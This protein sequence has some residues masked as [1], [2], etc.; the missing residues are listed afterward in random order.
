MKPIRKRTKSKGD[1]LPT[2]V[3]AAHLNEWFTGC[4]IG[5][6]GASARAFFAQRGQ[7]Y[8]WKYAQK[9]DAAAA[10][11]DIVG[12]TASRSEVDEDE[13][14]ATKE[15]SDG[16]GHPP[17]RRQSESL[18]LRE[19]P[20]VLFEYY[21]CVPQPS[22]KRYKDLLLKACEKHQGNDNMRVR[23]AFGYIGK[24]FRTFVRTWANKEGGALRNKKDGRI[25]ARSAPGLDSGDNVIALVGV[26]DFVRP[27]LPDFAQV[28]H[29]ATLAAIAEKIVKSLWP[30]LKDPVRV[31]FAAMVY[32][33]S[34]GDRRVEDRAGKKHSQLFS[35]LQPQDAARARA[36][37][38][39][40][41]AMIEKE[42]AN[43]DPE[44]EGEL[45][46]LLKV[47]VIRFLLDFT[48]IWL[49]TPENRKF[50]RFLRAE[51]EYPS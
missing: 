37:K 12:Q 34:L 35:Y 42:I 26:N 39:N 44:V 2:E 7:S 38:S 6:C 51:G 8:F 28:E 24:S 1:F 48:N 14:E 45:H 29:L 11:K 40:L 31:A 32:N 15:V 27:S 49:Q 4:T 3:Q 18:S 21:M 5:K 17:G 16:A 33:I 47:Q 50:L 13:A 23:V 10:C 46:A 22:G 20:W 36:P 41:S 30:R 9:L 19:R 43:L 25:S